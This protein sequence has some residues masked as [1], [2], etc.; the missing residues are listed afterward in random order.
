MTA[1]VYDEKEKTEIHKPNIETTHLDD[2][3]ACPVRS[4]ITKTF[5]TGTPISLREAV[6]TCLIGGEKVEYTTL[7]NL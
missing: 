2:C 3:K 1:N 6:L 5:A 4:I 7:A